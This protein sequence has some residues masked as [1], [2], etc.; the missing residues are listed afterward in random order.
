MFEH[1]ANIRQ[2]LLRQ[3]TRK[4]TWLYKTRTDHRGNYVPKAAPNSESVEAK[5]RGCLRHLRPERQPRQK[6][7]ASKK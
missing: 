1:S 6:V 5:W 7:N 2:D 3:L 4:I